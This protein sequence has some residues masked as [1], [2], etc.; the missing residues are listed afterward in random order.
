MVTTFKAHIGGDE[1]EY[2]IF[3]SVDD[4]RGPLARTG[5]IAKFMIYVCAYPPALLDKNGDFPQ[6]IEVEIKTV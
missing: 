5:Q 6:T 3:F 1:D 4:P 2:A